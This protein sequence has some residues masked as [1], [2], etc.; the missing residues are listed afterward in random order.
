MYIVIYMHTVNALELRQSLGK[1]LDRLK[2]N[3]KAILIEKNRRPAAVLISLEDYRRRFVDRDA[4]EARQAILEE[5]RAAEISLP[6]D[7]TALLRHLRGG[8]R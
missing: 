3:G 4:D 1:V 5:I 6:E 8:D 2:K 7:G